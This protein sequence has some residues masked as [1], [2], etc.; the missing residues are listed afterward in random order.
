MTDHRDFKRRVRDRQAQT[1]ESYM[2]ARRHVLAQRPQPE[3]EPAIAVVEVLD[4]T[5]DA[6]RL[7]F[8]CR[9]LVFPRL[10]AKV[11]TAPLLAK[12][13]DALLLTDGDDGT[14]LLRRLAFAGIPPTKPTRWMT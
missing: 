10:A 13:R 9:V 11:E 6:E 14:E 1:G 5:A 3:P 12:L 2:T 8:K 7:G 4:A